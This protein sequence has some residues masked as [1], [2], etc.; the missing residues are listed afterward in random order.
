MSMS[1]TIEKVSALADDGVWRGELAPSAIQRLGKAGNLI[2]KNSVLL[3]V[4]PLYHDAERELR[5]RLENMTV[6]NVGTTNRAIFLS[7]GQAKTWAAEEGAADSHGADVATQGTS[8]GD[9]GPGDRKFFASLKEVPTPIQ[10]I[11]HELLSRIRQK[12]PGDLKPYE[13]R[14]FINTPDNFWGVQ[15]QIRKQMLK[16]SLRGVPDRLPATGLKVWLDRPPVYSAFKIELDSQIDDAMRI[17]DHADR[18]QS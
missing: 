7:A 4:D 1:I 10:D 18:K 3:I 12:Y 17:I 11:G 5:F 14:R 2:G 8:L 9:Y 16:I 6:L 15:I 13:Q